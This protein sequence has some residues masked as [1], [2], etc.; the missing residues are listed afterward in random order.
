MYCL[1]LYLGLS[2]TAASAFVLID[3]AT[4]QGKTARE[5]VGALKNDDPKMRVRALDAYA[6][7]DSCW[8]SI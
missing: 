7:F 5:W 6:F 1:L 4:Y 3:D 8:S 2:T